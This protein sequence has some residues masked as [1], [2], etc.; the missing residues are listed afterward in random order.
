ML[1][2]G[3]MY[4]TCIFHFVIPQDANYDFNSFESNNTCS[5]DNTCGCLFLGLLMLRK[6]QE[7]VKF[8]R[9]TW[10]NPCFLSGL[11]TRYITIITCLFPICYW[12]QILIALFLMYQ[13]K[14]LEHLKVTETKTVAVGQKMDL[15]FY[16]L[17]LGFFDMD[18][19]LISKSIDKAKK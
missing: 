4:C 9:L 16:T 19:D 14:A 2:L 7:R 17:Q 3:Q 13:E 5:H 18:F 10:Q 11:W 8:V 15:V 12:N 6:T 1:R